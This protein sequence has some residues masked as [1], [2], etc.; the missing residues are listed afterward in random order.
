MEEQVS[1]VSVQQQIDEALTKEKAR[2]MARDALIAAV[3]GIL[4]LG[5]FLE[6]Y[7]IHRARRAKAIL[8]P[9]EEGRGKA[10]A[11]EIIGWIGLS[12]W[13]LACLVNML[14]AVSGTR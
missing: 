7:A 11:A 13:I 5:I 12:L 9:G 1:Q 8:V 4:F 2:N 14:V 10:D 3:V 6:P